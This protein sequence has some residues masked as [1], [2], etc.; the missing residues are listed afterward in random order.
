MVGESTQYGIDDILTLMARL[1]EPEYGCPWDLKQ[2][3]QSITPSTLE[4]AYEVV[5]TIEKADYPHLREEL[6]DLLF[7]VVFYSQLAEEDGFWNFADVVHGLTAKLVRRHPHVFPDGTLSSR[8]AAGAP[9]EAA[10]KAS[11]EAIKQDERAKKGKLGTLED[12]PLAL[13]ALSRAQKLQ[14]RAAGVGFDW[15]SRVAVLAK[16][17][18]EVVELRQAFTDSELNAN[19]G[20]AQQKLEEELGD[21]MFSCVNLARHLKCDSEGLMRAANRKFERRFNGVEKLLAQQGKALGE[22]D[23]LE[24]QAAWEQQKRD[25]A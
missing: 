2:T 14:K 15:D 24:M 6:G 10:I 9:E 17:E 16:L 1:R 4:E 5:D 19:H 25:E 20:A 12:V 8:R 3:Y 22:V 11:W 7:Q 23:M 18:E 21:V 13:P